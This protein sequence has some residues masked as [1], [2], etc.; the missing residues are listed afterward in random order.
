[1][2]GSNKIEH[3]KRHNSEIGHCDKYSPCL[4]NSITLCCK[5]IIHTYIHTYIQEE[6]QITSVKGEEWLILVMGKIQSYR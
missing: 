2:V 1:M 4:L 6:T 5:D 3:N